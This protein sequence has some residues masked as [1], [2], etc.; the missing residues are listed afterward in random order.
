MNPLPAFIEEQNR[1]A[2]AHRNYRRTDTVTIN[3]RRRPHEI[4][5]L[6][7]M[8]WTFLRKWRAS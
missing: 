1:S 2:Q 3:P 4:Q 6:G 8:L 5:H 7:R